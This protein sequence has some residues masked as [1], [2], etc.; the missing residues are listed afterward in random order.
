MG[1]V[2][3]LGPMDVLGKLRAHFIISYNAKESTTN[4]TTAS[5]SLSSSV[6]CCNRCSRAN[7]SASATS[8]TACTISS[9]STITIKAPVRGMQRAGNW[10]RYMG[11]PSDQSA[12]LGY[13]FAALLSAR[14]HTILAMNRAALL[15]IISIVC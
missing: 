8:S 15:V 11:A 14:Y 12:G 2:R 10:A 7:A 13:H 4:S 5:S 3:D 6:S 1:S 9:T